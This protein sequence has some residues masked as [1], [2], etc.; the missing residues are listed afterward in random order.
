[1]A[2]LVYVNALSNPFVYDDHRVILENLSI[3]DLSNVR[4]LLLHDVFRPVVNITY[5][6]DYAFWGLAPFGFHVTSVLLHVTNVVFLFVLVLRLASDSELMRA[7]TAAAQTPPGQEGTA[8]NGKVEKGGDVNLDLSGQAR[9]AA[10]AAFAAAA[11][12]AVHPLMTQAVGYVSG[13]SEVLCA[14]FFLASLLSLHP[15]LLGRRRAWLVLSLGCWALALTSKEVAVMLPFVLLAYDKLLLS[16]AEAGIRKRL[17]GVYVPMLVFTAVA[18]TAR[19]TVFLAVENASLASLAWGNLLVGLDVVRRYASLMFLASHQSIFHSA[20]IVTSL[21][22]P[23]VILD[24]AWMSG[25][26]VLAWRVYRR[27]PLVTFG[28][29]WFLL[30]LLPSVMMLVFDVGEPMAEQR[31]YLASGGFA[32]ATGAVFGRLRGWSPRRWVP[33]RV[34]VTVALGI[35][36]VNLASHTL[37]RN[38][39]WGDPVRLWKEAVVNT[40]DVWLPYRGLGDALRDREDYRGASQA[41]REAVRLRPQEVNTHLALG[42]SLMQTGLLQDADAAFAEAARLSPGSIQAE[43]GRGMVARLSARTDEARDRFL[44][45]ARAHRDAVLARQYLAEMYERDYADPAS[46]LRM[47]REIQAVAPETP[48]I[49]DCIT[50]N[51]RRVTE[52]GQRS[53]GR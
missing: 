53:S 33:A 36:L 39:V 7:T 27:A 46:A 6:I 23:L 34:A 17:T 42:V 35:F 19:L 51:E 38:E 15:W 28:T 29:L 37:V 50:R 25:L 1:M 18:G 44:A 4:A 16:S 52:L 21:L 40:P 22:R 12:W 5:A 13:R 32:M 14:L 20:Q 3:R 11:V 26:G 2:A 30:M 10:F 49:A 24:M 47:C 43:T 45:V 9:S 48:G 41:Y 31:L 8:K